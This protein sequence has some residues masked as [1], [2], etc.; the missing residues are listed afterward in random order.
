MNKVFPKIYLKFDL[1]CFHCIVFNSIIVLS[2]NK[3]II[4]LQSTKLCKAP[5]LLKTWTLTYL[6]TAQNHYSNLLNQLM[7]VV[8]S[9]YG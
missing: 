1:K 7:Q 3:W 4:P 6:P 8:T 5:S 2:P 9:I